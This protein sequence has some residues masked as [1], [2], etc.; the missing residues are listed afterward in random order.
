MGYIIIDPANHRQMVISV[1]GISPSGAGYGQSGSVEPAWNDI[2]G[3]TND[4]GLV[5]RDTGLLGLGPNAAAVYTFVSTLDNTLYGEVLI[6]ASAAATLQNLVDAINAAVKADPTTGLETKRGVTY[7]LPTWEN[8]I[9]NADAPSGT[10]FTI[11]NKGAGRSNIASLAKTGTAFSWSATLTSGGITTFNTTSL[12]VG[13]NQP[14]ARSSSLNYTPGSP[15]VTL[16]SPL[17]TGKNL[18]VGYYRLDANII[19]VEDTPLVTD[20]A[21]IEDGTGKYQALFSDDNAATPEQALAD[22]QAALRA[23]KVIPQTFEFIT[24]RPGLR[25]GMSLDVAFTLP[26]GPNLE[27]P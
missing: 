7:S 17:N 25:V 8:P 5:W 15:V 4:N 19:G 21:T 24:F 26:D 27:N 18:E 22:A 3:T 23:F 14:G 9:C 20:R 10:T 12:S 16:A 13:T 1:S 6:G 11:R 2:G